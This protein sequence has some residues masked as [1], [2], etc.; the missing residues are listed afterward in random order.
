MT[1]RPG[2]GWAPSPQALAQ[3]QSSFYLPERSRP[4]AGPKPKSPLV[5]PILSGSVREFHVTGERPVNRDWTEVRRIFTLV[6]D[7]RIFIAI[8]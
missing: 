4:D 8:R 1:R 5:S 6:Y 7:F 2:R 3:P